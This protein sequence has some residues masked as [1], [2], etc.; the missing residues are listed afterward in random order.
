MLFHKRMQ[1]MINQLH[2]K[3]QLVTT[4]K[5]ALNTTCGDLLKVVFTDQWNFQTGGTTGT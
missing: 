1:R 5:L 3:V 2:Y 4:V